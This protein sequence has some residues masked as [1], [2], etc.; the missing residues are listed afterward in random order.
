MRRTLALASVAVAVT[1]CCTPHGRN[2]CGYPKN[3][4]SF[5]F[6]SA[7]VPGGG[8]SVLDDLAKEQARLCADPSKR[9]TTCS[10]DFN[11]YVQGSYCGDEAIPAFCR[12]R[13]S[14]ADRESCLSGAIRTRIVADCWRQAYPGFMAVMGACNGG[15]LNE[16][17][18]LVFP[19][20]PAPPK[21]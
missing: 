10:T 9:Q 15:T 5:A 19:A 6:H 8:Q 14:D 1:A 12:S 3:D 18:D 11:Q 16:S 17:G 7:Q 13:C 21:C 4:F 2:D 20:Q